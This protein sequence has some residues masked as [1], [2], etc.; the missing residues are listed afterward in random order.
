MLGQRLSRTLQTAARQQRPCIRIRQPTFS[1]SPFISSRSCA[2]TASQRL[3]GRRWYSETAEVKKE[4]GVEEK[5]AE[6][7]QKED[8]VQKELEAKKK[9]VIDVT[10]CEPSGEVRGIDA[11]KDI[12]ID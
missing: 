12:R 5:P 4:D 10:V 6:E 2:P 8:P 1:T 7:A 9:E 11:Y 3:V